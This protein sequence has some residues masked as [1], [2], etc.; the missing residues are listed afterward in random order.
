MQ[1]FCL[2][3]KEEGSCGLHKYKSV[4]YRRKIQ[5]FLSESDIEFIQT[6]KTAFNSAGLDFTC[7]DKCVEVCKVP[8]CFFNKA[9]KNV[10]ETKILITLI[11]D[12]VFFR[13]TLLRIN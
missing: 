5:I 4:H 12:K 6:Y 2:E 7:S 3:Y 9:N 11:F 8:E 10:L 1:S 13:I